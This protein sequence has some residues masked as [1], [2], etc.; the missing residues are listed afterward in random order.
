VTLLNL[1]LGELPDEPDALYAAADLV[2][3]ACGGHAGDA[4]TVRTAVRRAKGKQLGAHPSFP[5]RAGFGRTRMTLSPEA[6]RAAL[7]AQC[8]LVERIAAEEGATVGHVKPHGA[9]YHAAADPEIA[10]V[11]LDCARDWVI[12][13]PAPLLAAARARGFRTMTEGFA[14]RGVRPDGSL[15]P[16]GEPGALV[17]DPA[18]AAARARALR[19]V[20]DTVCIHGD[21]PGAVQIAL[22][23]RRAL[24]AA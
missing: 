11:I 4:D 22:A 10:A 8:A 7:E 21:T 20:V 24:D 18:A 19:G 1:D 15:V 13:G 3:L 14:D 12:V 9:L 23:V 17:T 5:D 2:N 6:L 16:R